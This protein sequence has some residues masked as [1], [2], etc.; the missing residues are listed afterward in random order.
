MANMD[1][2]PV[3]FMIKIFEANYPESLG[4]VLVHKAPWI[5]QGIWKIIKGWLD[6]VVAAK[7]HFTSSVEDLEKF[8]DRSKILK[9]L[10]GDE[11]WEYVFV[12]PQDHEDK[13]MQDENAKKPILEDRQKMV[14]EFEKDTFEWIRQCGEAGKPAPEAETTKKQ[15]DAVA[16]QLH[17]NYWKLDPY[18][19]ARTLYDRVGMIEDGGVINFYPSHEKAK[20]VVEGQPTSQDDVD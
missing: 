5:F 8:I 13:L 12:E 16:T 1:Y 19:R 20:K 6:P 4:T 17:D 15:R 2:T 18:I 3:K 9:E 11:N 10:G 7:V 14:H